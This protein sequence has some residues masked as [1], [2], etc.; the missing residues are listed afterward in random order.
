MKPLTTLALLA[1]LSAATVQAS[2]PEVYPVHFHILHIHANGRNNSQHGEGQANVSED[3]QPTRGY[4]F[5][6]DNCLPFDPQHMPSGLTG[7]WTSKDHLQLVVLRTDL[8][9]TKEECI[10]HGKP[11]DFKYVRVDGKLAAVSLT[12]PKQPDAVPP[13]PQ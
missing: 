6:F 5:T 9:S 13:P 4:D 7:R 11:R 8:N 2:E 12:P 1:S 3:G 10:L